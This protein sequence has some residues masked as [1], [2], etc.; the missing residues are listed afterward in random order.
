MELKTL[1][2][3]IKTHLKT[4][5]IQSSKFSTFASILFNKKPNDSFWLCINYWDLNNLIINNQYPLP[6]ICKAMDWL[7]SAK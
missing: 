6:F 3:Y 2:T 7:G 1:K 4:G 5:F